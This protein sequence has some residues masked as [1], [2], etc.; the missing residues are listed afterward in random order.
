M[1]E[2]KEIDLQISNGL[3]LSGLSWGEHNKAKVLA[4][5]GWLDNAATYI[6]LA[7]VLANN[8]HVIALDSAGHGRSHHRPS[9]VRYH[10]IDNVDDVIQ[11][12]DVLGWNEF[13]LMGH[14]MGA[15]IS[16]YTAAA[17]PERVQ[18][19]VL[20]EGIGTQ[21]TEPSQAAETLH[22]AVTD[23]Q[24]A[25]SIKMP[26]Y[27]D[28]DSAVKSRTSVVGSISE[29][30]ASILCERGLIKIEGGYTWSSDPRLRMSSAIRLTEPLVEGFVKDINCPTL[31]VAADQ[32]FLGHIMA[33]QQRLDLIKDIRQVSLPGNHHHHLESDTFEPVADTVLRFLTG[34]E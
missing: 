21:T 18:K 28:I 7:P 9:G 15:G 22:K 34:V 8:F 4:L 10:L 2:P 17:F 25:P 24:R 19:L 23:M 27:P 1:A 6:N 13:N 31:F 11:V 16:T 12:A 33:V 29:R 26:L 32:G 20:L 14:S 30:A 3:T 5:H